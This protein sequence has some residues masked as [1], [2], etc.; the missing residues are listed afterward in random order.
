MNTDNN[1]LLKQSLQPAKLILEDGCEFEGWAFGRNK[2]VAGEVVF[3]T[4]MSGLV[5]ALTDPACKGQILVSTWPI[6]G[7]IGVPVNKNGTPFFDEQ[8][9]PVILESEKIQVS[10]LVISDL[11]EEPSHYAAKLSLS[12]W[13]DKG[14]TAGIC[15]IDTRAVALRIRKH[16]TMRGK[17]IIEGKGDV[18]FKKTDVSNQAG[19]A[20]NEVKTYTGS[21][22]SGAGIKIALIDC[23][24]KANVIRCLLN[25]GADV[26]RI[27]CN[28]GLDGIEYDGLL[29][30]N[31]PGDPKDYKKVIEITHNALSAKKPVFG[32]GLGSLIMALASGAETFKLPFGHRGQNQ[33][34]IME[35]GA[36]PSSH[37]RCYVTSQNHGYCIRPESLPDIWLQ[38]FTN[39]NDGTI[40]GIKHAK[41]PFSAVLFNPEGC[42]GSRD[43]EFVFDSFINQIKESK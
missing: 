28:M 9:I 36:K 37:N 33:P 29:I 17:I 32:I 15:G 13:F 40:E 41:K 31:G 11:C 38:W 5:Q 18:P 42:P 2:S 6:A 27:P 4:G 39:A 7:N 16:G 1:V 25:R 34:S 8:K 35:E 14:N 23:G 43:V 26:I 3:N 24:V 21:R 10:G 22:E 20:H 12:A 19:V 30:S